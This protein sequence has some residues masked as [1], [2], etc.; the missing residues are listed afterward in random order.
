MEVRQARPSRTGARQGVR[1]LAAGII[2]LCLGI[3]MAPA[4]VTGEGPLTQDSE[5]LRL[6]AV[7]EGRV[8]L[9][10]MNP[11]SPGAH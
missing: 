3:Q 10:S 4:A 8:C 1:L 5:V 6:A 9:T 2:I 11:S 7:L